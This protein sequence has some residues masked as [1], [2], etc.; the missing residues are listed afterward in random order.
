MKILEGEKEAMA[1]FGIGYV[2]DKIGQPQKTLKYYEKGLPI[3][4]E[5]GDRSEKAT[6]LNNIV[7]IYGDSNQAEKNYKQLEKVIWEAHFF[8]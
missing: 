6:T 1:D 2:S 7:V 8:F 5:V 4:P 3:L